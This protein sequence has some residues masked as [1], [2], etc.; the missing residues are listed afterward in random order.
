[1]EFRF[2]EPDDFDGVY[3]LE[4]INCRHCSAD[5]S[6][7]SMFVA[8]SEVGFNQLNEAGNV[9]DEYKKQRTFGIQKLTFDSQP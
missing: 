4:L 3:R 8:P 7:R 5:A 2:T 1:M 6:D 9:S